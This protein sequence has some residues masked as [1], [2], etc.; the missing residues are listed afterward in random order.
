MRHLLWRET[1]E[2]L[3]KHTE[4]KR[5]GDFVFTRVDGTPIL[6]TSK[7]KSGNLVGGRSTWIGDKFK[8]L[9]QRVLGEDDPRRVRELRKTGA[10]FIKQRIPG[11]EKLYLGHQDNSMSSHYVKPANK[12]LDEYLGYMEGEFGFKSKR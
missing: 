11:L 4:G 7:D 3:K 8:R 1:K 5:P 9:V 12:K 2:L 6:K 10:D